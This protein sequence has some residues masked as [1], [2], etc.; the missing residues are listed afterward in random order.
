MQV[1][2]PS[3]AVPGQALGWKPMTLVW[4]ETETRQNPWRGQTLEEGRQ[5]VLF[6]LKT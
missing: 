2:C 3:L 6:L 1:G 4:F 5:V